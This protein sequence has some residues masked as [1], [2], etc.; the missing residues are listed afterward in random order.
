MYRAPGSELTA[1]LSLAEMHRMIFGAGNIIPST[2][3]KNKFLIETQN[4]GKEEN[5][6]FTTNT[7]D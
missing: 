3:L 6:C 4:E 5:T 7:I 2:V 1:V